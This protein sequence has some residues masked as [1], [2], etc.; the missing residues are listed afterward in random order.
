MSQSQIGTLIEAGMAHHRAGRMAEAE[1]QYR[2]A[3][4]IN[5]REAGVIQ[6]LGVLAHQQGQNE[7][8]VQWI[9]Q[10]IAL[11]PLVPEFHYN[12]GNVLR[13][14]GRIEEAARAFEQAVRLRPGYVEAL[15]NLA[16]M[17]VKMHRHEEAMAICR[18][19]LE[20]RPQGIEAL[21]SLAA[22]LY[23]LERIDEAVATY[24]RILELRPDHAEALG[25][26]AAVFWRQGN[27]DAAIAHGRRAVELMPGSARIHNILGLALQSQGWIE[28]AV[29]HL[30]LVT[31][32]DPGDAAGHSNL[33]YAIGFHPGISGEQAWQEYQRW[34]KRHAE[35]LGVEIQ[36]HG[37]PGAPGS[38]RRIRIGYVSSA[39]KHG[40]VGWFLEPMFA[41]HDRTHFD[42]YC[43]AD[44]ARPDDVTQRL[45]KHADVWRDIPLLSDR[46]VTEV[47]RAER[48]DI[49]VDLT[50]HLA[51]NRLLV[52]ARKPA[53]IQVTYLSMPLTSGLRV[54]DYMITDP[55]LHPPGVAHFCTEE[56]V[57]L[58]R[59]YSCYAPDPESPAVGPLPAAERGHVTFASTNV[60]D[61]VNDG[62]I[63]AWGAILQ[64][65]P[66]SRLVVRV[67]GGELT[68]VAVRKRF[69]RMGIAA[70]RFELVPR[71]PLGKYL[72]LYNSVDISLDT[73]PY[74]GYTVAQES[75]WMGV[76]V[77]TL[78]GESGIARLG[79]SVLANVGLNDLIA[80]SSDQY[81]ET[82]VRLAGDVAALAALRAGLRQRIKESPLLDAE[83]FTRDIERLYQMMWERWCGQT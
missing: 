10:A 59:C 44:V 21:L 15:D 18:R 1:A 67:A 45:Q 29:E 12:F 50:S 65:T 54:M 19:S 81:V 48:I 73:F 80:R 26:L 14:L 56:L 9:G 68:N 27:L 64:R 60:L 79:T 57:Y 47:I 40:P 35:P 72:D 28:E 38:G 53:P 31:T 49:L 20:L 69:E 37:N 4:Q 30:R 24:A 16:A 55:H 82:A 8:A 23:G 5:P 77:V 70:E 61:K 6:L 7:Q 41:Q 78:G 62:V 74:T 52:F 39:F 32:L 51:G 13:A 2:H 36:P 3:L 22:A 17:L 43:Y 76:P 71:A 66:G 11:Q 83:A 58:S 42:I 34:A 25:D 33:L 63:T 46:Q 75:L